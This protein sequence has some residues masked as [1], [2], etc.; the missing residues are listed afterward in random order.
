MIQLPRMRRGTKPYRE[1]V[2]RTRALV[3]E[4]A[5][6]WAALYGIKYGRISIR[7]QKT[8]WGSC[9][10][11]GNLNFNYR[12]GFLPFELMDYIVVHELCHIPEPNH[13]AA[14]WDLVSEAYPNSRAL[15]AALRS[16]RF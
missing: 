8:R 14:F 12:L 11:A 9:S 4:R 6:Y 13:S 10:R 5:A 15:R 2:E 16:Y 1:A 7:K 3:A